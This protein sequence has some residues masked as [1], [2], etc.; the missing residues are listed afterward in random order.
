MLDNES[1]VI[2]IIS[3]IPY[4]QLNQG[5]G[6]SSFGTVEFKEVGV[7]LKV[8]PHLTREGMIRLKLQP[9]FSVQTGTA[10]LG[11]PLSG[12]SE[13]KFP[14]PVIDKRQA[15]TTLLVQDGQTV[16]LGGLRKKSMTK[17]INKIP[18]L[19]DLPVVGWLFKFTGESL[20]LSEIVVFV[21]PHVI[22]ADL[23][24]WRY[25]SE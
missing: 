1:A 12:A 17:Q 25:G 3:E 5:V 4:L 14:V 20:T 11:D 2:K 16:V 6:I 18:C 8:T 22:R 9:E 15:D 13:A 24:D 10:D 21:T 23:K 7:T 19:G